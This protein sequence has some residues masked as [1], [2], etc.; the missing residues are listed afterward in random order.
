QQVRIRCSCQSLG[1]L[2]TEV[3]EGQQSV[4]GQAFIVEYSDD[5]SLQL[6]DFD[7]AKN[8]RHMSK[9]MRFWISAFSR[10]SA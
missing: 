7:G 5:C 9:L 2:L 10:Q 8:A 3:W 1:S 4:T 6:D